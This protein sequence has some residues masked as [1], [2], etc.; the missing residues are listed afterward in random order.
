MMGRWGRQWKVEPWAHWKVAK[1]AEVTAMQWETQLGVSLS[2][3][4]ESLV[5]LW[6]LESGCE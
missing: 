1:T 5:S 3:A 4:R 2:L 6:E